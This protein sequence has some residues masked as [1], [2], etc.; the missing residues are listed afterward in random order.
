MTQLGRVLLANFPQRCGRF[1]VCA[2]P[3][4]HGRQ[5]G[6]DSGALTWAGVPTHNVLIKEIATRGKVEGVLVALRGNAFLCLLKMD[7]PTL[8]ASFFGDLDP[9]PSI[10]RQAFIQSDRFVDFTVFRD[11]L[12]KRITLV[13]RR[14]QGVQL[15]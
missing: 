9:D 1:Q 8:Y 12:S 13:R 4:T 6:S 2:G 5:L 11:A 15:G 7:R 3:L 14:R 10:Q